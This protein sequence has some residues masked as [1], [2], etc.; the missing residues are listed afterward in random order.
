MAT[1]QDKTTPYENLKNLAKE[2]REDLKALF[3]YTIMIGLFS[4]VVP[5]A[6]Q[7]LVN[8]IAAGIFLQPLIVM[9]I[10]L[11]VGLIFLVFFQYNE[12]SIVEKI[13]QRLFARTSFSVVDRL[14]KA[15]LFLNQKIFLPELINRFFDVMTIQKTWSKLLVN[16]LTSTLQIFF[17]LLLIAFYNP[18][19][20][21]FDFL[22]IVFMIFIFFFLGKKGL[23]TSITESGAKYKVVS[24]FEE[25][26]ISIF[27]IKIFSNLDFL[28]EKTDQLV[29][30][31]IISRRKH[32]NIIVRQS[33]A[34]YLFYAFAITGVFAIGGYLVIN[35]Q[36][37]LGQLVASEI[38]I[39]TILTGFQKLV[40]DLDR[41]YDLLTALEKLNVLVKIPLENNG[42]IQIHSMESFPVELK[43]VHFSY[44][45]KEP[46]IQN[47]N[48]NINKS[49]KVSIIGKSGSGKS[50]LAN[51]ISGFYIPQS[52]K[53]EVNSVDLRDIDLVSYRT[54][55]GFVNDSDD[56]FEG[57]VE[58]NI[59][60]GRSN[61]SHHDISWAVDCVGLE[62]D[63]SVGLKTK[64]LTVGK[65]L[66]KGVRQKILISRA[67]LSRPG[68]LIFDN[69]FLA[70][71]PISK[72]KILDE[73]YST[74]YKWTILNCSNDLDLV[75][76]SDKI[77]LLVDGKSS[78]AFCAQDLLQA[79]NKDLLSSLFPVVKML[80]R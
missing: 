58:E 78:Q 75:L 41:F 73:L 66:S 50:T 44:S 51:L 52:G 19:L 10:L 35:R 45:T 28:N 8:T 27:G 68:I 5:L 65:N 53:I 79:N 42:K 67:I 14:S 49:E 34:S 18:L 61:I 9:S 48:L 20:L 21:A 76:K 2:D 56:F 23:S 4:L 77:Y 1:I 32:F 29:T 17:G 16:G 46:L 38:I 6:T 74:K 59:V 64:V 7:T 13:Q 69:A 11:F 55:C 63:M 60:M 70:V 62:E 43:N 57:T 36:L 40:Q 71:D 37:T 22:I 15:N 12:I 3:A 31:Y 33:V 24:W 80:E 47:L 26:G 39:V 54:C 30:D 25:M 72:Q